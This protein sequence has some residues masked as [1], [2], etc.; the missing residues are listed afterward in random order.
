MIKILFITPSLRIRDG[1]SANS[2]NLMTGWLQEGFEVLVLNPGTTGMEIEGIFSTSAD[3]EAF[4]VGG[5]TVNTKSGLSFAADTAVIQYAISTYWL[6]TF[7][8]HKWLRS[9]TLNSVVV[10]CH[11]LTREIELLKWIGKKIYKGAFRKSSKIVLFST[12]AGNL[13]QGLT[14]RKF[15]FAHYPFLQRLSALDPQQDTHIF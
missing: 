11:E 4:L 6:R 9:N 15:K 5:E 7:W 8:I 12:E 1:I 2:L 14:P 3:F 13:A 10:L